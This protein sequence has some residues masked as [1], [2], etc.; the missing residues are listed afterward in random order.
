MLI[1]RLAIVVDPPL[2]SGT[3]DALVLAGVFVVLL[4]LEWRYARRALRVGT[5]L[6]AL[7]VLAF[8]TPNYT[9]ARRRALG[10]AREQRVSPPG[11][12]SVGDYARGVY[13]M[14]ETVG[15][16]AE[17]GWAARLT[18]LGALTWLACTPAFRSSRASAAPV[19]DA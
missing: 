4:G 15:E 7:L 12:D 13:T 14:S 19:P 6:L 16:A 1:A 9:G 11:I 8:Y 5:V 17:F 18:A 3:P 2:R 10:A